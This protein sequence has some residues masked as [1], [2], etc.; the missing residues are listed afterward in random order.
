MSS[1][2][3]TVICE[4]MGS[5]NAKSK[6]TIEPKQMRQTKR[7]VRS[8]PSSPRSSTKQSP[9]STPPKSPELTPTVG[10]ERDLIPHS[11]SDDP[12]RARN[13]CELGG[14]HKLR[15]SKHRTSPTQSQSPSKQTRGGLLCTQNK[16]TSLPNLQTTATPNKGVSR[17]QYAGPAFANSPPPDCL[18]RPSF[19]DEET[20]LSSSKSVSRELVFDEHPAPATNESCG[21]SFSQFS[22]IYHSRPAAAATEYYYPGKVDL[23]PYITHHHHTVLAEP[24]AH[25]KRLLNISV[26]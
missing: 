25:L 7:K 1:S 6:G 23:L 16:T 24:T 2:S 15:P 11:P 5:P 17:H 19:L 10:K 4:K 13:L 9:P 22:S 20:Y 12:E 26:A 3:P 21:F 14:L 18:P 8:N